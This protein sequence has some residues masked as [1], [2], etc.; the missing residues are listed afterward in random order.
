MY[1]LH[2]AVPMAG[3]V[4]CTFNTQH[5]AAM[6]SG[7]KVFLA[8]SN[9]LYVGRAALKR[10]AAALLVLLTISDDAENAPE[11][12][13][14]R[15]PLDELDP[16][17]LNYTSGTTS[18]PKGVVGDYLS[19]IATVL[20]DDITA[21]PVYLWTV[22]MFH[23]NGGWNLPWGV[24]MEGGTNVIFDSI[25]RHGV[26]H[27]GGDGPRARHEPRVLLTME[28]LGF[29]ER[30]RLMAR[31]IAMQ[32]V[33][34][35]NEDTMESV[36]YDGQTIG[37]VMF[38]GNT[39]T[40]GYYK[41][42]NATTPWYLHTGYLQ[43]KDRAKDIIV[44]GGDSISSIEVESVIFSHPE[45]LEAAVM[46][47]PDETN[48]GARHRAPRLLPLHPLIT[49]LLLASDLPAGGQEERGSIL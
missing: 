9:L 17:S 41:D 36:P 46:A 13:E 21:M 22:P 32:D 2:F 47:R 12:I 38:R 10:L 49:P 37:E 27:T 29:V 19:T 48:I 5:D 30:A 16:I 45:V 33:D 11:Q 35:N 8:E 7:A 44:S 4:F 23:C 14:I 3:A 31:H 18:R 25:A 1:E 24:A 34:V 6:H 28:E 15:W 40:S 39:V 26:T 43:L 42:L 20:T